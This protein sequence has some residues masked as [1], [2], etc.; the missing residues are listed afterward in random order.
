MNQTAKSLTVWFELKD[1]WIE[2]IANLLTK[3]RHH[4]VARQQ[5]LTVEDQSF[6]LVHDSGI[7][8]R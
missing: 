5:T 6:L 7:E 8:E 1:F 4:S 2:M 3:L